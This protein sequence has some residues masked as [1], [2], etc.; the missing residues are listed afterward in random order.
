MF[1][2]GIRS[3]QMSGGN[4]STTN[5]IQSLNKKCDLFPVMLGPEFSG[6]KLIIYLIVTFPSI[7]FVQ[8][9]RITK[10]PW[11]EFFSKISPGL[12][13]FLIWK[14][15]SLKPS[16]IIFNHH[17]TFLYSIFFNS[18]KKIYLARYYFFKSNYRKI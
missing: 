2:S 15:I 8:L 12:W 6:I 13:F 3:D 9:N 5:I 4:T 18:V 11:L 10:N 7:I 1:I 14:Y 17:S 16:V